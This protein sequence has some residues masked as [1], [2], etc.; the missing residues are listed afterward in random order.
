MVLRIDDG[1][2]A[3]ERAA[4]E[5]GV[6]KMVNMR[7]WI[8]AIMDRGDHGSGANAPSPPI[9]LSH[10]RGGRS[11]AADPQVTAALQ[12]LSRSERV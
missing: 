4:G 1:V 3:D 11:E 9:H 8:G 5:V 10:K 2:N 7:S 12:V 6:S